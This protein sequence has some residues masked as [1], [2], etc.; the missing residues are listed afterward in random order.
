VGKV[1]IPYYVIVKGRGYWRTTPI[2]RAAGFST[3]RCGKDG[4]AAWAIAAQW[5]E[6]WQA[7]R[8]GDAPPLFAFNGPSRDVAEVARFYPVGSVGA[9]FQVYIK[10]AEWT[11]RA[12]SARNKVWWPAWYRIRDMWGDVDPNTIEFASMSQWRAVLERQHG[13]NVAHKNAGMAFTM[14]DHA[15]PAD[16][17][18]NR[19]VARRSQ[20]RPGPSA[21]ALD[22]GRDGAAR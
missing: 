1:K 12:E 2:M 4:P 20:S 10:T 15:R 3:V 8:R 5:N 21:R 9:A 22:R 6:R 13:R 18:G 17:G 11:A 16:R 14:D 7:V 19:S